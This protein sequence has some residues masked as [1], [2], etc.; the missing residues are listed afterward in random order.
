MKTLDEV[1]DWA[2]ILDHC[3][4]AHWLPVHVHDMLKSGKKSD[5][6]SCLETDSPSDF[7]EADVK[8]IDGASMV[9][10]L[11]SFIKRHLTTA[12][13]VDV[14][15]IYDRYLSDSLKETTRESRGAGV[16]Q[17]LP[18]D[19]N[20][21]VPKNWNSYLCNATNKIELFQYLSGV[22]AQSVFDE[23][24]VVV[25]TFDENVLQNSCADDPMVQS[26]YSL[27]P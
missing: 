22:I 8:L 15:V 20:G 23:G 11:D 14:I 18:S 13:H 12:K 3:N 26:E 25:T 24:K 9:H 10:A 19:G 1:A 6:V 4:Y 27:C 2:F 21:K 17:H 5:L 16:R 7:D